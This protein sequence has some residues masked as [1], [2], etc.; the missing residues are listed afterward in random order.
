M[1]EVSP[2]SNSTPAAYTSHTHAAPAKSATAAPQRRNDQAN[3]SVV[4]QM[5]SRISQLPDVRQ[6]VID[7]VRQEI[8]AG[9][10]VTPDKIEA[11]IDGLA[12]DLA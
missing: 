5:L 12:E 4:A 3:F 11:A 2:I 7:R 10:Y 1:N 8:Q 9:T 6:D